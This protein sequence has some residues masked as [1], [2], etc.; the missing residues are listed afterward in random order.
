MG[1][2][3]DEWILC[4]LYTIIQKENKTVTP[5]CESSFESVCPMGSLDFCEMR[6]ENVVSYMS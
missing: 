2:I 5:I 1:P 4:A 6:D 3:N